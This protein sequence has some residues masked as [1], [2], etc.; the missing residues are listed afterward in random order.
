MKLQDLTKAISECNQ[1]DTLKLVSGYANKG[2]DVNAI[3]DSLGQGLKD[4]GEKFSCGEAF[5]PELVFAGEIFN[6]TMRILGPYM[7]KGS[8]SQ[9]KRRGKVVIA[10]VKGDLHDIGKNLVS[11]F[12][13][14]GGYEVIDLGVDVANEK[15]IEIVQKEKPNVIGLSSLLTTTMLGQRQFMA[16]LK[17]KG[18]RDKVKVIVG[19]A[20]VSQAWADEIGADGYGADAVDGK[21]K[22]DAMLALGG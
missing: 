20:P 3:L 7:P 12:L 6:E 17:E 22:I 21:N 13:S 5:I 11:T 10:T 2:I 14:L 16:M 18:L 19:G 4:L 9:V 1:E 8:E 15:L